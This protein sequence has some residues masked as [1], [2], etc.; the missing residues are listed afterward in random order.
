MVATSQLPKTLFSY[1]PTSQL[2]SFCNSINYILDAFPILTLCL[3]T[4]NQVH[5]TG[6]F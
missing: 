1:L 6:S 4:L 5:P 3:F 2:L